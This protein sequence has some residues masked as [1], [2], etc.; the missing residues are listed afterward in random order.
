MCSALWENINL[1]KLINMINT[2]THVVKI[3]YSETMKI[4]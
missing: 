1:L 3:F 4:K 2:Q